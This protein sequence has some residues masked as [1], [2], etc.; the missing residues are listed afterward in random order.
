[1]NTFLRIICQSVLMLLFA[2]IAQAQQQVHVNARAAGDWKQGAW[3]RIEVTVSG[4]EGTGPCRLVQ[5][6]PVGFAFRAVELSGSDLFFTNNS[7][8]M[9]WARMPAGNSVRVV[10]E[11]MPG[12]EVAGR[13]EI[14][15]RFYWVTR[16]GSRGS[17]ELPVLNNSVLVVPGTSETGRTARQIKEIPVQQQA[18]E[19]IVEK[20]ES[21]VS[22]RVQILT[23]SSQLTDQEL[24]KRLGFSFNDKVTVIQSGT[25]YRYQ[26]GDCPTYECALGILERFKNAGTAGAFITAFRGAE[27]IT[28][29]QARTLT[30]R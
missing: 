5:D 22:F 12:A 1:M 7:L 21:Q 29:E 24:K 16:S 30:G 23:S 20:A 26:A 28:I 8:N 3:S 13:V 11:V 25:L 14:P 15:G 18:K 4:A 6:F 9:V 27:Q 19:V 10:Y 17:T 2:V